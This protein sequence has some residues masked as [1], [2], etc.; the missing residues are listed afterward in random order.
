MDDAGA[1]VEPTFWLRGVV[2]QRAPSPPYTCCWA[3]LPRMTADVFQPVG[4]GAQELPSHH[5]I[6][7]TELH[8]AQP[9]PLRTN[10]RVRFDLGGTTTERVRVE[11][12]DVNGRRVRTL[13]NESLAPG[14]YE[15]SWD[16]RE[17]AGRRVAAGVYFV[18]MVA[19]GVEQSKKVVV[20][21]TR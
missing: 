17:S 14:E 1:P 4:V 19:G 18:R 7:R 6:A 10:A 12:F 2:V 13:V 5:A 8:G 15:T 16:G 21:E 20:L 9:N 3:V 11:V